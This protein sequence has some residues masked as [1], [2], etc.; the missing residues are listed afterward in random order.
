MKMYWK[1][2]SAIFHERSKKRAMQK[3][4]VFKPSLSHP[5]FLKN[6]KKQITEE[7]PI[8]EVSGWVPRMASQE[9]SRH[10]WPLAP[11]SSLR[12]KGGSHLSF[13]WSESGFRNKLWILPLI[14]PP[15]LYS[16]TFSITSFNF[17]HGG[18]KL[19]IQ[20]MKIMASCPII[21]WQTDDET[22]ETVTDFTFLSSKI[23]ADG[24]CSHKI[25][26]HFFSFKKIYDKPRQH[27]KKQRHYFAHKGSYSQSYGSSS[28]HVWMWE[29]N[30]KEGWVP[31]NWCFWAVVLEKTLESP[32]DC[33]EIKPVN[34]KGNQS[35][36]FI[37]RDWCWSSNTL[38]IWCEEL[39]HLRRPWCWERL[40]ARGE[41]DNSG[42]DD[43]MLSLTQ[44]TWIWANSGR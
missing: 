17:Q 23:T 4:T 31:K 28:S 18:L 37:G 33:K 20:K 27:I 36:I 1:C 25:K 9:L 35:W 15:F 8:W 16:Q 40:K 39:T 22:M 42:W 38:T 13:T 24:H 43:W 19:N 29:F 11:W 41:V 44:W 26:R 7:M 5:L 30:H 10:E 2:Y 32:L 34:S 14:L 6:A 3:V 21:S 12:E